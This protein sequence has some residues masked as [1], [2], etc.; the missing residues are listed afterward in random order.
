M[1]LQ[2]GIFSFTPVQEILV[3]NHRRPFFRRRQERLVASPR[4][5]IGNEE[6]GC[7]AAFTWLPFAAVPNVE[8]RGV[9][10]VDSALA[11]G[12]IGIGSL[13]QQRIAIRNQTRSRYA[14]V[15]RLC[16]IDH[17]LNERLIV[18]L[19]EKDIFRPS[20][21]FMTWYQA[22][23]YSILNGRDMKKKIPC[24]PARVKSRLDP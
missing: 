14:Q 11:P 2:D 15:P 9:D 7:K 13:N 12:D 20:P 19:V 3:A 23:G 8:A 5:G 4:V 6:N 17:D 22:S 1:M 21:R 18:V 10:A 16:G 24:P